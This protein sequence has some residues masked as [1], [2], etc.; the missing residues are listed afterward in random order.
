MS[1]VKAV[2]VDTIAVI[3]FAIAGRAAHDETL[4]VSQVASTAL[5][6]LA[7]LFLTWAVIVAVGRPALDIRT[8]LILAAG[9]V[10]IGMALRIALLGYVPHISFI[11]VATVANLIFLTSWRAITQR[12]RGT[13]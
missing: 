8:G 13:T 7:G 4:T 9:V 11:I 2:V 12:L 3:V 5:P 1:R 10:F 6:F